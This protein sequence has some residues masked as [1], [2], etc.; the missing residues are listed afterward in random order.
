MPLQ[1]FGKLDAVMIIKLV[2]LKLIAL[3]LCNFEYASTVASVPDPTCQ[4][5]VNSLAGK[6]P[7]KGSEHAFGRVLR[8][9]G[10]KSFLTE[11]N[12]ESPNRSVEIAE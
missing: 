11:K 5:Y 1:N 2:L 4:N 6:H 10:K 9:N 8:T 7:S 12:S 3:I